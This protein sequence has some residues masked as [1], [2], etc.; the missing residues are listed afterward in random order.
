MGKRK[1]GLTAKQRHFALEVAT[2]GSSITAPYETAYECENMSRAAM[3]NEASKLMANPD[4]AMRVESIR[5]DNEAKKLQSLRALEVNDRE[6]VL[7]RL[8]E[9]MTTAEPSDTNKIAAA[10]LLGQ[11]VGLF[12]DV[13]ISED[14]RSSDDIARQLED[15][16]ANL[17][18]G[19]DSEGVTSEQEQGSVH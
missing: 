5:S 10:R 2:N 15:R 3:R 9:W 14:A 19:S 16:L 4:I 7:S 11:S 13:T 12:K 6:K 18:E 1:D 17:L 8:R